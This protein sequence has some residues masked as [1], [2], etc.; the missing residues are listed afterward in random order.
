MQQIDLIKFNVNCDIINHCIYWPIIVY[1]IILIDL[2]MYVRHI[3]VLIW[4]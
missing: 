1:Y 2:W 3:I 4:L